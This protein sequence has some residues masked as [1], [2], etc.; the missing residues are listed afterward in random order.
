MVEI[1]QDKAIHTHILLLCA[2]F[3][4][5]EDINSFINYSLGTYHKIRRVVVLGLIMHMKG[6]KIS[7]PETNSVSKRV[8]LREQ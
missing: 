7:H 4:L 6:L 8:T 2:E 5:R 1:D 3:I